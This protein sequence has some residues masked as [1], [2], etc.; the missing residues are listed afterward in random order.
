[1]IPYWIFFIAPAWV[2]LFSPPL[3]YLR[4]NGKRPLRV[5][6]VWIFIIVTL[7]MV[8]GFRHEV[9][10]DWGSYLRYFSKAE[11]LVIGGGFLTED[12]GYTALNI[13]SSRLN[14]GYSGVNTISALIFSSGLVLF[15]RNL[16]RPWLALAC[17]I[18]YLVIVVSMGY[19]RQS[20]ALGLV[21]VAFVML[22]RSK[23][24]SF[25]IWVLMAA[26]FHKSA[27]LM[28]PI[29]A[30]SISKNRV[31]GVLMVCLGSLLGFILFLENLYAQILQNYTD[32]QMQSSG[33]SI[34]LAMNALAGSLFLYYR[35]R[36]RLGLNEKKLWTAIS[37]VSIGMLIA[38]FVSNISTALD[39]MAL[40]FIPLQLIS[41]AYLPDAIGRSDRLNQLIVAG[42]LIYYAAVMFVWLNFGAH[43]EYWLPY[44]VG[45]T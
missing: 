13:L 10:G 33:A 19:T 31:L 34:R 40:Y 4:A 39:R 26:L 12:P 2:A 11:Y 28:I 25:V 5:D 16:P 17:A 8:V 29:A 32:E 24:K 41:F 15:C 43:S 7:T 27:V 37:M 44:K 22:S 1:M 36:Y 21:M 42:I 23:Y 6:G 20:T 14:L 18:P 35:G 45:V 30:L 9:G 38:F 3:K